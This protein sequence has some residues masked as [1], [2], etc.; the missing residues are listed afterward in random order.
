MKVKEPLDVLVR[1]VQKMQNEIDELSE[2][3]D[4]ALKTFCMSA[5]VNLI[6]IMEQV[7]KLQD[8]YAK[9]LIEGINER[10]SQTRVH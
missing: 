1:T 9:K 6:V 4:S 2:T 5:T 7:L 8:E 3:G 10:I